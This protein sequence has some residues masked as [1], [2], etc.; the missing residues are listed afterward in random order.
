[1][2]RASRQIR[3]KAMASALSALTAALLAP[4]AALGSSDGEITRALANAEWTM[5]DV[6]AE[7]SWE[8]CA[9]GAGPSACAW[10]P[11]VTIG[12]GTSPSEC[13]SSQRDWP[14]LG[15]GIALAFGG[16]GFKGPGTLTYESTPVPLRAA[17]P[18]QLVCLFVIERT[19][20]PRASRSLRLDAA[21]L[22]APPPAVEPDEPP[23]EEE[24]A[25]GGEPADDEPATADEPG[26][27]EQPEEPAGEEQPEEPAGEEQPEELEEPG[28][29]ESLELPPPA[30]EESP[31]ERKEPPTSPEE[32]PGGPLV[33]EPSGFV[34]E[35]PEPPR[36]EIVRALANAEWSRGNIAG[37]FTADGCARAIGA[38]T[39]YC[40]WIPYA[41]IGPGA[42]PAACNTS[43]RNWS[44]LGEDVSLVLWGGEIVGAVAHEFDFPGIWLDDSSKPLLCL[45]AVEVTGAGTYTHRLD[46][47]LLTAPPTVSEAKAVAEN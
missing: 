40:A 39:S 35:P 32:E 12:P 24:E 14:D 9:G 7:V 28:D 13:D 18:G 20:A 43:Q 2:P 23:A 44:S 37:S 38:S 8:G 45:A 4:A 21:L 5:G 6:A 17:A 22:T 27:V 19:L 41:T 31:E 10:I 25:A 3:G 1:M 46:A 29:E 15:E 36:G 47:A 33:E 16:G 26:N 11:Y 34:D 30:E 42:S